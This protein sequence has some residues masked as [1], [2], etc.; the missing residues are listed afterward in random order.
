MHSEIA[1]GSVGDMMRT[2]LL[3][4]NAWERQAGGLEGDC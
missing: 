2:E 3:Q 1:V 4:W